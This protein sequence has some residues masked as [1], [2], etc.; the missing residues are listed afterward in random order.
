[1]A[2]EILVKPDSGRTSRAFWKPSSEIVPAPAPAAGKYS[3]DHSFAN[4]MGPFTAGLVANYHIVAGELHPNVAPANDNSIWIPDLLLADVEVSVV[5]RMAA[6]ADGNLAIV[7]RARAQDHYVFLQRRANAAMNDI[8][9]LLRTPGRG[10]S[11]E[12]LANS[13]S[14]V[15]GVY[16]L[17]LVLIGERFMGGLYA[18]S[19]AHGADSVP[20]ADLSVDLNPVTY[21]T[22]GGGRSSRGSVGI[23]ANDYSAGRTAGPWIQ[24][25]RIRE[26]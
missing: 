21:P 24:S 3:L 9:R 15:I 4:G 23:W 12:V 18:S 2:E 26:L 16:T 11:P 25:I 14:K 19:D 13:N 10:F 8:Q 1:M 20:A 6:A 17:K 7:A 5:Y 22:L